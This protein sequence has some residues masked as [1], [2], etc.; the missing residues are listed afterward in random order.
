[1]KSKKGHTHIL[2]V[3]DSFTKFLFITPVRNT[4]AQNVIKVLQDIFDTFRSP[5]RII[6]DRGSCF[7]SHAFRRF[8]LDR[9]IKHVL[10]TVACPRSNGQVERYNRTVLDSLTAQNLNADEKEWD[11]QLGRIQSGD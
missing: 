6:S 10:N 8:C 4:N 1:M 5:D 9:R 2:T 3:V 11:N 7:T